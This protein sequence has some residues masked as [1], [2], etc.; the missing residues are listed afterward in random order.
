MKIL[1]SQQLKSNNITNNNSNSYIYK[2]LICT[3]YT[4]IIVT[5]YNIITT[6]RKGWFFSPILFF[7]GR[8]QSKVSSVSITLKGKAKALIILKGKQWEGVGGRGRGRRRR[9]S[10]GEKTGDVRMKIRNFRNGTIK[11]F[12]LLLLFSIFINLFLIHF[13][14]FSPFLIFF[15]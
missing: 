13:H 14:S 3:K 11:P 4:F 6:G 15:H 5:L 12:L 1:K 7:N 8:R 9:R 2:L 10:E